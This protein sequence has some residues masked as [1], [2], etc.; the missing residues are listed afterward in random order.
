MSK[1]VG[2]NKVGGN[3]L[4]MAL[5][6]FANKEAV[7]DWEQLSEIEFPT[8]SLYAPISYFPQAIAIKIA[9]MVRIMYIQFLWQVAWEL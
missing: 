6:D 5:A 7:L 3:I 2:E 9:R 8:M 4:P 1:H